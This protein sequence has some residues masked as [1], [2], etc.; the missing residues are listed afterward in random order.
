M[1]TATRIRRKR[2]GVGLAVALVAVAGAAW[3]G[4]VRDTRPPR[5]AGSYP[6][7]ESVEALADRA[8]LVAVG[9][10]GGVAT[11]QVEDTTGLPFVY[12]DVEL[13]QTL[14]DSTGLRHDRIIVSV[15][16]TDE[17]EVEGLTPLEPG[18]RVLL[19]LERITA[20]DAP[21]GILPFDEVFVPLSRDNGVFDVA[22]DG[23]VTARS[24]QVVAIRH[25]EVAGARPSLHGE[26][27]E[28]AYLSFP[29][30]A[31]TELDLGSTSG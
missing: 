8:D 15:P 20:A 11:R 1:N 31:L 3:V 7:Y 13:D 14:A 19:F 6:A 9:T 4:S 23:R 17:L 12:L 25:T 22:A 27:S 21:P 10:V 5:I 24:P 16:D 30:D 29:L 26:T 28:A 18:Q 2:R